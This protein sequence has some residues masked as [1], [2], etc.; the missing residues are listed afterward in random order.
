MKTHPQQRLGAALAALALMATL[1]ACGGGS[2]SL[3]P[4]TV[5][6]YA[7]LGSLQCTGGGS[8]LA[9]LQQKLTSAGVQVLGASCGLDGLVRPDVCGAPDGRIA[10]LDVPLEYIPVALTLAFARL[11]SLPNAT[12][13]AC[14]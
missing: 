12:K 3:I 11:G 10:I 14:Q 2:S 5:A 8:S 1:P 7:P 6:M 9:T 13:V 4:E